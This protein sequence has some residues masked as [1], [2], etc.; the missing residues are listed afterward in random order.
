MG[1]LSNETKLV[2]IALLSIADDE[3]YF[4]AD[5]ALI[6]SDAFPFNEGSVNIHGALTELS[7]IGWIELKDHPE[8]GR[9]GLVIKFQK[10]Q[11]INRPS[12]SKLKPY[13]QFSEPSVNT[14]GVLSEPSLPDQ[15]SGNRDQGTGNVVGSSIA[16]I[17]TFKASLCK[18][19]NGS[20][21]FDYEDERLM[22]EIVKSPEWEGELI[23]VE[24][25]YRDHPD[26]TCL[27]RS[28][29][30][31]LANW[32]QTVDRA[33][34]PEREKDHR[35]GSSQTGMAASIQRSKRRDILAAQVKRL[36]G[37]L[38][39]EWEKERYPDKV[40]TLD[41]ARAELAKI[42]TEIVNEH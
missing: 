9:M 21:R 34:N 30:K 22:V 5:P 12:P 36:E 1:R 33:F 24:T 35:N 15:G 42:E 32:A 26:P 2:A 6:R 13:Y 23:A 31:L 11:K 10:H 16:A 18:M 19:F 41:E 37:E 40:K 20:S 39:Y 14:H 29:G 27:P 38:Q 7:N 4:R 17:D 28:K 8:Q 25:L 3:G